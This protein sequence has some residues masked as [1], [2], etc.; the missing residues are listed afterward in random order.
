M[1]DPKPEPLPMTLLRPKDASPEAK[2]ALKKALVEHIVKSVKA[3]PAT[4]TAP[5]SPAS[6]STDP[7]PAAGS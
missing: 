5:V 1:P 6:P 3:A 7:D 4:S 2:E